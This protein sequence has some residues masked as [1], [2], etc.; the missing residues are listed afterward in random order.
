[1][2]HPIPDSTS[3]PEGFELVTP[4]DPS[5]PGGFDIVNIPEPVKP[6]LTQPTDYGRLPGM[7]AQGALPHA[8]GAL[9]G[10]PFGLPGVVAGS[11]APT[12]ADLASR[13]WNAA[14]GQFNPNLQITPTMDA[15]YG[16]MRHL[17]WYD[18]PKTTAERA[19][20]SA[21]AATGMTVPQ[22]G[23]LRG[24]ATAASTPFR[25]N[26]AETLSV[27]PRTQTAI[28]PV[29]AITGQVVGEKTDSPL[30]GTLASVVAGGG[31]ATAVRPK[32]TA[33]LTPEV[34]HARYSAKLREAESFGVEIKASSVDKLRREIIRAVEAAGYDK[35]L[36]RDMYKVLKRLKAD[37]KNLNLPALDRLRRVVAAATKSMNADGGRI[38][39]VA[40][41]KFDE[42]VGNFQQIDLAGSPVT[43]VPA[44]TSFG[45]G[46]KPKTKTTA[47]ALW[48]EARGLWYQKSRLEAIEE[49][50][51]LSDV[52][53]QQYSQ[54]GM[55][56]AVRTKFRQL[57]ENKKRLRVFPKDEQAMIRQVATGG[58]MQKTM[59]WLGRWKTGGPVTGGFALGS[60][61]IGGLLG[62][63]FGGGDP[64]AIAIGAT[65]GVTIPPAL[66]AL[67]RSRA[68]AMQANLV[69]QLK[70]KI[71]RAGPPPPRPRATSQ[72][73]LR[74]LL[75]APT[76]YPLELPGL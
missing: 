16:A 52:K 71:T 68:T 62:Y 35:G 27:A 46:V 11:L 17:P 65:A 76:N 32:A 9:A 43:A 41:D 39:G 28:A 1:M 20:L 14:V 12:L 5:L 75:S 63:A 26:V 66:G 18:A 72:G 15:I 30:L 49:L 54:S 55:E 50:L 34:L 57:Y 53:A 3:I 51:D 47:L 33:M 6:D 60:G 70:S 74:G 73:A 21:G 31:L 58:P 67:G 8:A 19:A 7:F 69:N 44:R 2:T 29:S 22:L 59:R 38:A 42:V 25:R 10:L 4:R 40:K 13:G 36:H 61:G 24:L 64:Q 37:T 48:K 56:N 23:G 45:F